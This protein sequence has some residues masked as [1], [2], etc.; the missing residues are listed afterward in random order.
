M[1]PLQQ[2]ALM[3]RLVIDIVGS[4]T[5]LSRAFRDAERQTKTFQS[6]M[7]A[8]ARTGGPIA[9]AGALVL[10]KQFV[11]AS[12]NAEVI[13]GQTSVAVSDAGLSW[14]KYAATIE[15]SSK[16]ISEASAFDDEAVLQ[17]FQVFVIGQKNVARSFELT[18]LAADVARR[19]YIDL[20]SA[21]Q[22]VNKA[23]MGQIGALRR[24]G[25]NIDKNATAAQALDILQK[26]Y[27][28]SARV[29]ADSATG[30]SEKLAVAWENL[31]EQAGG[32]L[33]EALANLADQLTIIVALMQKAKNI[34]IPD[35]GFLGKVLKGAAT[36]VFPGF[37]L[38]GIISGLG[39][40]RNG[41]FGGGGDSGGGG[42][43][44]PGAFGT[45]GGGRAGQSAHALAVL[46]TRAAEQRNKWFDAMIGRQRDLVQDIPGLRGQIAA[47]EQIAGLITQRIAA[48]KDITRKLTLEDQLR[49]VQ[50]EARGDRAQ[51]A[52]ESADAAKAAAEAAKERRAT[53]QQALLDRLQLAVDRTALT[54]TLQ[55]DLKQLKAQLSGVR[56][57]IATQGAT[58]ALKQQQ[59]AVELA[60]K[61]KNAQIAAARKQAAAAAAEQRRGGLDFA[62]ERAL[63]T[64]GTADE[65]NAYK[66]LEQNL[67]ARIK[68]E[69]RSLDLVRDLWQTRQAIRE[70]NKRETEKESR[71]L[72]AQRRGDQTRW[73]HMSS[74]R[75]IAGLGL[76]LSPA[77]TARLRQGLTQMGPGGVLPPGRTRDFSAAGGTQINIHN[78][79]S[80]ATNMRQLEN[81][82][83]KRS[84]SRAHTRRGP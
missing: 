64:E 18:E 40:G 76:D 21:T 67:L 74:A 43:F 25:I 72:T 17:S 46:A 3:P 47:L 83:V 68:K 53:A 9:G 52:Q 15:A 38:P 49:Q 32:P 8:L 13:L 45:S 26:R 57:I 6:R 29:Y 33:S 77:Q 50:R 56:Q 14:E 2:D 62:I 84:K 10:A 59:L 81:D 75:F 31:A 58:L 16:R 44:V 37:A 55:D 61:D 80:S 35:G 11:D 19:R 28:G 27:A 78:F 22:L 66:R 4:T 48:T 70:T 63:A 79:H 20:A 54:D 60:I 5:K 1:R 65:L 82:L 7:G 51:L 42:N 36:G 39:R 73:R 71:D 30:S 41:D 24:A 23:A 69:G 12:R 34:K